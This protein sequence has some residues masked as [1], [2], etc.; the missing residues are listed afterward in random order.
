MSYEG[1]SLLRANGP[2]FIGGTL[3]VPLSPFSQTVIIMV[4]DEDTS[5]FVPCFFALLTG[6]NE[7]LY[8]RLF[9]EVIMQLNYQWDPISV[10]CDFEIALINISKTIITLRK[11]AWL[12]FSLEV[13]YIKKIKKL[14]INPI[15]AE[16]VI[17]E[18]GFLTILDEKDIE[19][20]LDYL[21]IKNTLNFFNTLN[22]FG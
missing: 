6:K 2:I 19:I 12:L 3:S 7:W 1:I 20:A 14:G 18:M 4:Y 16:S 10:T 11:I 13:G 9:H 8:F 22:Q 21:K 5:C 17:Y 15:K